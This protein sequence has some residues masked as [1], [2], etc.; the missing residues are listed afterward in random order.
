[1]KNT[2]N[3]AEVR[4]HALRLVEKRQE[5]GESRL[6]DSL[7]RYCALIQKWNG[8]ASLVSAGDEKRLWEHVADSLSLV[9][10]ARKRGGKAP[11]LLDIGSGGGF[12][13]MPLALALG[14]LEAVLVD[15]SRKKAGFLENA[16][17]ELGLVG[18]VK[19]VQGDFPREVG[20]DAPEGC[21][22]TA[23][24]VEKPEIVWEGV[25][26]LVEMGAIFLCQWVKAPQESEKM[27]HVERIIDDWS[28][29]GLRRGE[30]RLIHRR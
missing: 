28:D 26:K 13:A 7:D 6:A 9:D 2:K 27:F 11:W 24:A 14:E 20:V 12:P 16:V 5:L 25:K 15:R 17:G 8:F 1:M 4:A 22:I 23:R 29:N 3:E 30:L 10:V 18:R 21:L 19:V